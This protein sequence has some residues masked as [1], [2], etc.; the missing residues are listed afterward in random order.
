M[1]EFSDFFA[2]GQQNVILDAKTLR[3]AEQEIESC[4]HCNPESAEIPFNVVL[5]R[6]TGSDPSVKRSSA[7]SAPVFPLRF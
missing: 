2:P 5:D 7:S 3:Q 6:V 4:E 1:P